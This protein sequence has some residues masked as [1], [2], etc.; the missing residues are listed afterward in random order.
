MV[1]VS[2]NPT[3]FATYRLVSSSATD[4]ILI[5]SFG[6]TCFCNFKCSTRYPNIFSVCFVVKYLELAQLG[7]VTQKNQPVP[8][9]ACFP[10]AI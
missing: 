9:L 5:V 6:F 10:I 8:F 7:T 1:G 3:L 4:G 2:P